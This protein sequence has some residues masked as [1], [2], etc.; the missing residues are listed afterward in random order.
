MD[1]GYII[2]D[3]IDDNINNL[4]ERNQALE[5]LNGLKFRISDT[6][7][8]TEIMIE[9][10]TF[11]EKYNLPN[12]IKEG[13]INICNEFNENID[14]VTARSR[15]EDY[16]SGIVMEKEQEYQKSNELVNDVKNDVIT[17]AKEKLENVGINLDGDTLKASEN[18]NSL[19]SVNRIR[20]NVDTA[21]KYYYEKNKDL[22]TKANIDV[23]MSNF[24]EIVESAKDDIILAGALENEE[25]D[26]SS[27]FEVNDDG[28]I[29]V[30]G[31]YQDHDSINFAVM[32][33][34]S[35]LVMNDSKIDPSLDMKFI[36][37]KNDNNKFKIIYGNFPIA[38]HPE[39]RLDPV[40]ISKI[41]KI[42][43]TYNSNVDYMDI[44]GKFSPEIK[45]AM[46]IIYNYVLNKDGAFQ[47]AIRD[48]LNNHDMAFGMDE[49]YSNILDAFNT[50]GAFISH[51]INGNGVVTVN[52]TI[53]GN[54]LLILKSTNETL[55]A[56][57]DKNINPELSNNYQYVKKM[58]SSQT[59]NTSF[60]LLVVMSIFEVLLLGIYFIFIFN[61]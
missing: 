25:I 1:R 46:L 48:D 49:N 39:N 30:N 16:L 31:N 22:D 6:K 55:T 8:L 14:A 51:D 41:E 27:M 12:E 44:L 37:N 60:I 21:E 9:V 59:G 32:M 58:E 11:L 50:N 40:L 5:Y 2:N 45:E 42:D 26:N 34:M 52:E 28:T 61:K 20:N 43:K 33:T 15:L 24:D 18:I 47:M 23:S 10:S 13:I 38:N 54:Q 36:K 7:T 3:Y 17:D 29:Q 57:M 53:P 4:K 19:D 56:D 35:L